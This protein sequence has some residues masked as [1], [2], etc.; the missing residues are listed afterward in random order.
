MSGAVAI[1]RH[2]FLCNVWRREREP[3]RIPLD[4]TDSDGI[5]DKCKLDDLVLEAT[6]SCW[7]E[8]FSNTF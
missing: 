5:G 1:Q 3:L 8:Q 4:E 6:K 7:F 2:E